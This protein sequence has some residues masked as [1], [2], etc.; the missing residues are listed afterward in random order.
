MTAGIE[1]V[2][3]IRLVVDIGIVSKLYTTMLLTTRFGAYHNGY[4]GKLLGDNI[5]DR[6][7]IQPK[8]SKA[9]QIHNNELL[10]TIK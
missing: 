10:Q 9:Y 5:F 3:G 7:R 4:L 8:D 2:A 1:S 6:E